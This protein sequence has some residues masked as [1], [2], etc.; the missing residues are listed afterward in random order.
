MLKKILT[1]E[2]LIFLPNEFSCFRVV[3]RLFLLH[4]CGWSAA[5]VQTRR[6]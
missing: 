6:I 5:T 3:S 1:T 4:F 2:L